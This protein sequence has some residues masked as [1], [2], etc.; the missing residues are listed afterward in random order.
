LIKLSIITVTYNNFLSLRKTY[1]SI[2][3]LLGNVDYRWIVIDGGSSDKSVDFLNSIEKQGSVNDLIF[4]SESDCG[5][6][7]A[8][9]KGLEFV[10]LDS[11]VWF[12]NAGDLV[13]TNFFKISSIV[14]TQTKLILGSSIR[15]DGKGKTFLKL[16][17]LMS[18]IDKGMIAEHQSI[19]FYSD[20]LEKFK[21][22][23]SYKLSSD[24]DFV[25]R[26]IKSLSQTE[27]LITDITFCK[28]EFG[29]VS[30]RKR[31]EALL[32]DAL[33]RIRVMK[34]SFPKAL[35]LLLQ[36]FIWHKFKKIFRYIR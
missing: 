14:Q 18:K 4:I 20:L 34:K 9:N 5:L 2:L 12:L 11:Y 33:I 3:E 21:Y 10:K 15:F 28:F 29:G 32:E 31:N 36:H 27:V 25:S 26:V 13:G 16:P 6:Y 17:K 19:L 30:Y 24:Y 7:D 35:L 8:M 23:L 1:D 22:D